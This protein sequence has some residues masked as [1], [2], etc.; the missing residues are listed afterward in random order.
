MTTALNTVAEIAKCVVRGTCNA[1]AAAP[2][3]PPRTAP[4]DHTACNELMIERP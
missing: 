2:I 3:A 1:I 4:I